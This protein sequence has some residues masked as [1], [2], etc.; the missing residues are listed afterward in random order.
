MN[1]PFTAPAVHVK[2]TGLKLLPDNARVLLR[3]FAPRSDRQAAGIIARVAAL[4]EAEVAALLDEVCASFSTRHRDLRAAFRRRFDQVA[5]L[6]LTDQPISE[7]RRLLIGA[8]F[9]HEYS[10]EAAALFNPAIVPHPEAPQASSGTLRCVLSLRATGEGH[11]SSIA[12]R[13]GVIGPGATLTLD[14][15]L[16]FSDPA[17]PLTTTTYE[18]HLFARKLN[19]LGLDSEV[20]RQALA[21]VGEAF[22]L[23]QLEGALRNNFRNAGRRMEDDF[24]ARGMLLLA[25]SNYEIV[26]DPACPLAGRVIFPNSPTEVNGIEDARFVRFTE[27]DGS[28]KY[29]A[30]YTA[31][32]GRIILPQLLE[33][34]DFRSF[35]FITLNGP[36][37]QN[38]GMA[39]FP[40]PIRG[41]YA[42]LSRQD[43]E[44]LYLMY[45]DHPHFWYE[46]RLIVRPTFPW[47]FIQ[48]GNC[49][50]PIE[51]EKGWLVLSHGVGPMRRYCIGA[52]LLDLDDPSRVIGRMSRP[53]LEPAPDER[54]GYVPNVVYTCGGLV[55]EDH[56]ILPYGIA[57]YGV[58]FATIPLTEIFR[59]MTRPGL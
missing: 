37:V 45:S 19:E 56:L 18:K 38:K 4:P 40:R 47:E 55:H 53:L 3:P 27:Q 17:P 34:E 28:T 42:M 33:T 54:E 7:A 11:I 25:H 46:P 41:L 13:T 5:H 21:R 44:N 48:V 32:D 39:L 26:F 51:T 23:A 2:R 31:Y 9:T 15:P 10:Y 43:G 29:Y 12:F 22:T 59:A 30:T 8:Y 35:R 14:P 58:A 49:G 6:R 1:A 36:A 57:D 20:T 50:S 52:F 24:A 16:P